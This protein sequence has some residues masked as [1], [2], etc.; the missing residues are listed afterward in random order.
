MRSSH[1]HAFKKTMVKTKGTSLVPVRVD[2]LFIQTYEKMAE[3][4]DT[5]IGNTISTLET[6]MKEIKTFNAQKQGG[7]L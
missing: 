4:I 1:F 2:E 5:T 3:S 7:L 6:K